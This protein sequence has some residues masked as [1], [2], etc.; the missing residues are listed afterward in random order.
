MWMT[1]NGSPPTPRL[2]CCAMTVQVSQAIRDGCDVRAVLYWSLVDNF[3]WAEGFD[4]R[5]GVYAWRPGDPESA[6]T[7]RAS[8]SRLQQWFLRLRNGADGAAGREQKSARLVE[9]GHDGEG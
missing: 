8:G 6:R 4:K 9:G 1:T 3:E 7:L 2:C 5:F